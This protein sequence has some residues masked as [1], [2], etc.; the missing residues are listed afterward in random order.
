MRKR[1]I[2]CGN[3]GKGGGGGCNETKEKYVLLCVARL[4]MSSSLNM[5]SNPVISVRCV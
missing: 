4:H 5:S 2:M 3:A 1:R